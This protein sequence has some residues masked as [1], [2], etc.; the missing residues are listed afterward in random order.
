ML[1]IG[2]H[3]GWRAAHPENTLEGIGAAIPHVDF[4]EI[5]VRWTMDGVAVLSHD[6]VVGGVVIS[7][8]TA[9][10]LAGHPATGHIPTLASVMGA[11]PGLPLDIE[12]KH[13]PGDPGFDPSFD[14]PT[15]A[16]ALARPGDVVTAFH[17]ATLAEVKQRLPRVLTGILVEPPASLDEAIEEAIAQ[18]HRFV[19]PH[20]GMIEG[21]SRVD[22]IH[23]QGLLVG[24][25]TV[26]D[27]AD[28]R[29]YADY[30]V[31]AIVTDD[32][33]LINAEVRP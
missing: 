19:V 16:A 11:W 5:D 20:H 3:R 31:D 30:G 28:A 13:E 29:R 8:N 32:P 17:A 26:N 23:R 24:V 1:R 22:E 27:P 33:P 25:W 4:V 10:H 18:G 9:T 12:L 6:P 2:G 21:G 15:A 7:E 14:R